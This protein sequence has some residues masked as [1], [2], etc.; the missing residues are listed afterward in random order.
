MELDRFL[1]SPHQSV[2]LASSRTSFGTSQATN[3][4]AIAD[5]SVEANVFGGGEARNLESGARL[6]PDLRGQWYRTQILAQR[7]M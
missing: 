5:K 4:S 7:A 1:D 3:A 6:P 2:R